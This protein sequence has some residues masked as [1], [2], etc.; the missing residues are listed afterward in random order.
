MGNTVIFKDT[1][2]WRN[3]YEGSNGKYSIYS[4]SVSKKKQDDTW[5]NAYLKVKFSQGAD[6]P[7]HIPNGTVAD[8]EGFLTTDVRKDKDG[9]ERNQLMLM[10]MRMNI[11]DDDGKY[12]VSEVDSFELADEE[13]PF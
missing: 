5:A 1:K 9:K 13:C 6:A 12:D 4:V 10:V 8:L 7:E 2:I 3:D 11:K